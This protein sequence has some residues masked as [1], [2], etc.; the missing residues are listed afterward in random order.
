MIIAHF[1]L[2]LLIKVILE[3][4]LTSVAL[5]GIVL[6]NLPFSNFRYIV[7]GFLDSAKNARRC[8]RTD[9]TIRLTISLLVH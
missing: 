6:L 4:D 1:I 7:L 3:S 5:V 8:S 2:N 9:L